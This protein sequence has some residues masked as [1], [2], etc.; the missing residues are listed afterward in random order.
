M[1]AAVKQ[2]DLLGCHTIIS[3]LVLISGHESPLSNYLQI[4]WA[5]LFAHK[6]YAK[7]NDA[8]QSGLDPATP[9]LKQGDSC[10]ARRDPGNPVI[11]D[12]HRNGRCIQPPFAII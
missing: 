3:F 7:W 12:L 4:A 8:A 6:N 2:H 5:V 11:Q 9:D 1:G 10:N